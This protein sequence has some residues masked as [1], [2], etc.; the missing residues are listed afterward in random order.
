MECNVI[1]THVIVHCM[2]CLIVLC[3]IMSTGHSDSDS[4]VGSSVTCIDAVTV[5]LSSQCSGV[6]E[7]GEVQSWAEKWWVVQHPS[8][9]PVPPVKQGCC[10]PPCR[11]K[12]SVKAGPEV[13]GPPTRME[14]EEEG[15]KMQANPTYLPIEVMSYKSQKSYILH[16]CAQL[17]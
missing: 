2:I 14:E 17:K 5:H 15:E 7:T 4:V 13:E 16:Q 8:A 3:S 12:G 9:V 6:Q 11:G 10:L 1:C